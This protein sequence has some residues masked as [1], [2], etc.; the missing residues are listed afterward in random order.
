MISFFRRVQNINKENLKSYDSKKIP[1]INRFLKLK[2]LH[3]I[4]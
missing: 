1:D 3:L 2:Y 4:F